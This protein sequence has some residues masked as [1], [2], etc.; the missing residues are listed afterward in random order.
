MSSSAGISHFISYVLECNNILVCNTIEKKQPSQTPK[1][2]KA[3][4]RFNQIRSYTPP[5]AK[6]IKKNLVWFSAAGSVGS[7]SKGSLALF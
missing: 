4:K 5:N 3:P 1:Y 2:L 7:L 6:R